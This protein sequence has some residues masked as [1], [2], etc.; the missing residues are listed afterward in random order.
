[1]S[2]MTLHRRTE[3]PMTEAQDSGIPRMAE[4][5]NLAAAATTLL[6]RA[7]A[8]PAGRAALTLVPGAGVP[9]KQTLLALRGGVQLAE[10][11]A[12]GAATLQVLQGR[13][14]LVTSEESWELGQGDHLQLPPT[15][16]R[17]ES[18]EDAAV[19]LTVAATQSR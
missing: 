17:L 6:E 15:P 16:H 9:L 7:A 18:L 13:V 19:L 3:R 2:F 8:A 5:H 10:H 14:R 4:V 11:D 12:P 1:M